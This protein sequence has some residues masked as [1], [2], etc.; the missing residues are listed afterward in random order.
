MNDTD[1]FTS[2]SNSWS[3]SDYSK[4]KREESTEITIFA[5]SKKTSR[6]PDKREKSGIV[7]Q[8]E[9]IEERKDMDEIKGM[10][11]SLTGENGAG[12]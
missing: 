8:Q 10:L 12:I 4:R 7:K 9:E 6:S 1:P 5:K 11:Q 3:G 2:R